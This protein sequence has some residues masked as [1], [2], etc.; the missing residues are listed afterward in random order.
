VKKSQKPRH[1]HSL[2]GFPPTHPNPPKKGSDYRTGR[3]LPKRTYRLL[4]T[5]GRQIIAENQKL[6]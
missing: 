6:S 5:F 1:A 3:A 2:F 4:P